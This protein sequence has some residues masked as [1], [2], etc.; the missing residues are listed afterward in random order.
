M[1]EGRPESY[2]RGLG[3][4]HVTFGAGRILVASANVDFPSHA[5]EDL[6]FLYKARIMNKP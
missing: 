1:W 2:S 6:K 5:Q 4:S 3:I